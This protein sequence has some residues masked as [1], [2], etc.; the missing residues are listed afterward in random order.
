MDLLFRA[1]T[2]PGLAET[3]LVC[4]CRGCLVALG[5][6]RSFKLDV[7]LRFVVSV[8][9][10]ARRRRCLLLPYYHHPTSAF[11]FRVQLRHFPRC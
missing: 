2:F 1:N 5:Q 10:N 6:R 4:A 3:H 8:M 9:L 7:I 11:N